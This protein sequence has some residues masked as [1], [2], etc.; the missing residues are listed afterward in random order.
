MIAVKSLSSKISAVGCWV[1]YL[2]SDPSLIIALPCQSVTHSFT[3]SV[4]LLIFVQ[5]VGFV[6]VV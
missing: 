3:H 6:K 1:V 4:L 5:I 2:F